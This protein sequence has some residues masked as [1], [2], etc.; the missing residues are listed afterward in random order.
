MTEKEFLSHAERS[1]HPDQMET[2][3]STIWTH[4][5]NALERNIQT[6]AVGRKVSLGLKLAI[7]C[8]NEHRDIAHLARWFFVKTC[9][10]YRKKNALIMKIISFAALWKV[11][12]IMNL[13][14][15]M[16]LLQ[17]LWDG[18]NVAFLSM[19]PTYLKQ[20]LLQCFTPGLWNFLNYLIRDSF[21]HNHSRSRMLPKCYKILWVN[22]AT[23]SSMKIRF[24]WNFFTEV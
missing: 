8:V 21:R 10:W 3:Y 7:G 4:A 24:Y 11:V 18:I 14:F 15:L 13:W 1:Q 22:C 17:L 16:L 23:H 12:F 20:S 5:Q 19:A 2:G 9:Q 6:A